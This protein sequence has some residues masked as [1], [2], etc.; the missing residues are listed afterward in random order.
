[1]EGN[2]GGEAES[3]LIIEPASGK[4]RTFRFY[5]HH[6]DEA[7]DMLQQVAGNKLTIKKGY[8]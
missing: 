2:G 3:K 1:M 4:K 5:Q 6:F 8:F 7:K